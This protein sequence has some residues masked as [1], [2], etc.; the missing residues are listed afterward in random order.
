[1]LDGLCPITGAIERLAQAQVAVGLQRTH[2]K[3]VG[4]GEG[5]GVVAPGLTPRREGRGA[6]RCR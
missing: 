1:V 2:L 5:L 3:F 6:R 4:P